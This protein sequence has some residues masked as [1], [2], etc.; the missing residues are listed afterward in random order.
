[1]GFKPQL[2]REIIRSRESYTAEPRKW[3]D[4]L[5]LL[6][7]HPFKKEVV[8]LFK[9]ITLFAPKTISFEGKWL[10]FFRVILDVKLKLLNQIKTYNTFG[11]NVT[12]LWSCVYRFEVNLLRLKILNTFEYIDLNEWRE[13]IDL[14][15]GLWRF[16]GSGPGCRY[17]GHANSSFPYR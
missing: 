15:Q 1:M 5:R 14:I 8:E 2:G 11:E 7:F 16:R 12:N 17:D 3:S 10:K 13:W 9:K 4:S 6:A